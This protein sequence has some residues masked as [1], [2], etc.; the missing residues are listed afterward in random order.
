MSLVVA[1]M[2]VL[3]AGPADAHCDTAAGPLVP[4]ARAALEKGDVTPLLKWVKA[5]DETEIK[6]AFAKAMAVRS[7][8]PEARDLADRYFLETLVRV[9]RA[10]EGAA[11]TGI[12][13]GPMD[14][15]AAMADQAL[16]AG[17]AD[18]MIG[19]ISAHMASAIKERFV[20][21]ADAAKRKDTSVDA[22][23]EF[24]AAY[25]AY[26]HYVEGVHTAIASSAAH[27]HDA[28]PPSSAHRD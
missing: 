5:E 1:G 7:K 20:K 28:S 25:V 6:A 9:H 13:D 2:S 8:G 14:P 12:K 21:A 26:M 11:Y 22:G 19:K 3:L 27:Q 18:D 23:R 15:I 10:G 17:A 4:E 24:V 16:A